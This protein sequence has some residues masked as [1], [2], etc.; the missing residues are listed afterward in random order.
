[1]LI[2]WEGGKK[3]ADKI[4]IADV[5]RTRDGLLVA[6]ESVE[7][8]GRVET[9]HNWEIADHH[10]YCVSATE[11][12][13]SVW[14]H[15]QD[16]CVHRVGG[17]DE[18]NLGL[19]SREAKLDPPGI[20]VLIGG[21]PADTAAAFRRVFG[22]KSS[23]GKAAKTVGTA[24]IEKIRAAGF[25]VVA[26]PTQ[27]FSNHGRIIH[28]TEGAAGFTPENLQKLSQVFTNTTGL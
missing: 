21:T 7:D 2:D 6:V 11:E 16:G 10:T 19:K 8:S 17:G 3:R 27:N 14:A 5:P 26:V 18:K 13:A 9:V 25:D 23:L 15:N 4:R 22:P 12:G 24:E 20:S 28:P 1:M